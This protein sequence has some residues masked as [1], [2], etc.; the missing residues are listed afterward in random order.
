[1]SALASV[2][3]RPRLLW[4]ARKKHPPTAPQ[5]CAGHDLPQ[6]LSGCDGVG[7]EQRL[8]KDFMSSG[9]FPDG[10]LRFEATVD[11]RSC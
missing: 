7:A 9:T 11:F 4:S 8:L 6:P 10:C 2:L 5:A 1:M 3:L